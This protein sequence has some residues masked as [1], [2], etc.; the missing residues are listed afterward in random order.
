MMVRIST[1]WPGFAFARRR[2]GW[3]LY[4]WTC[5]TS[6]GRVSLRYAITRYVMPF[7]GSL[8][9]LTT[10]GISIFGGP[11]VKLRGVGTANVAKR[12]ATTNPTTEP[13]AAGV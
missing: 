12:A 13:A 9:S 10:F 7:A 1:I 6:S 5:S 3:A 11:F 4:C 8:I 2:A